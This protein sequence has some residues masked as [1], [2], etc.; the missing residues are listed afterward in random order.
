MDTTAREMGEAMSARA[1]YWWAVIR[2]AVALPLATLATV[3]LVGDQSYTGSVE[4]GL[5]YLVDPLP[6]SGKI[7]VI[8]G[9]LSVVALLVLAASLWRRRG[10]W[11]PLA[12][13]VGAGVLIGGTYRTVT[14]GVIG[15]NIGGGL[16]L[17]VT[18]V[19]LALLA[20]AVVWVIRRRPG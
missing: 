8:S 14:A 13:S 11:G 20:T 5:D 10:L 1:A 15:A 19:L 17:F 9:A 3:W 7:I 2:V 12:C 18:P 6:V 4:G 16:V